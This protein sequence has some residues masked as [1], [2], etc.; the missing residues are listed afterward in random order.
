MANQYTDAV[1]QP[2]PGKRL[3]DVVVP[4]AGTRGG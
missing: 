2:G 1:D 4:L 3:P